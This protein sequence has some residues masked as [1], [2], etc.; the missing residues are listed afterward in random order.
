MPC[1]SGFVSSRCP[2][3]SFSPLSLFLCLET[4]S[5]PFGELLSTRA[6]W[7]LANVR[8]IGGPSQWP[9]PSL[10]V[11][12]VNTGSYLRK[13]CCSNL[14]VFKRFVHATNK[15]VQSEGRRW[16]KQQRVEESMPQTIH[17]YCQLVRHSQRSLMGKIW[18]KETE[19][20]MRRSWERGDLRSS[21]CI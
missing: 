4:R 13:V 16:M 15:L 6:F 5:S 1:D 20:E 7:R 12:P 19:W 10:P 18:M 21:E 3:S 17:I 9:C 14:L 11:H 2:F 8:F